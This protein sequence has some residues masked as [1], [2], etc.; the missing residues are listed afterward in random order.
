MAEIHIERKERS[1]WPWILGLLALALLVWFLLAQRGE[2][3]DAFVTDTAVTGTGLG[4]GAGAGAGA[5]AGGAVGSFVAYVDER[6]AR[7]AAGLDHQYTAEGL[8]RLAD[9]LEDLTRRHQ[10]GGTEIHPRIDGIR[11][12]ADSLQRDPQ[13]REHA[14]LTR[15]GFVAAAE[16]MRDLQQQRFPNVADQVEQVRRAAMNV[17]ADQELLQQNAQVQQF[18]DRASDAVQQMSGTGAAGRT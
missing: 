1:V 12:R 9:A 3:E 5:T 10:A 8:R 2:R 18:F 17:R 11:Q 14:R 13:S 4:F 6:R 7:E 15:E 16:V